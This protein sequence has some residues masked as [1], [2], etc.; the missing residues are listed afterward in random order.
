ML[1]S[2]TADDT[3]LFGWDPTPGIVS[4]WADRGGRALVWQRDG[5]RVTCTEERFRP[6]LFAATLEDLAHVGAALVEETALRAERAPFRYRE[7]DGP[8]DSYRYLL[9]AHD[10]RA[11]ERAISAGAAQRLGKPIKNLYDVEENYYWVGPVE[12]YL[13]ATGRVYFR[14]LA[15]T[16]LHRLQFDLETT[17]LSPNSG[18][19]FL[20]AVRDTQ[21]LATVL[22]AP[23]PAD[24]ASLI[25]DLCALIRARDPDIIENHNLFGFDLPFLHTRARELH[26]PLAIGRP[27]GPRLLDQYEE[28]GAFRRRKRT[29]Y[30]LAGRELIDTLDAVWRHDFSARDMPGHGLKAAARYFGVAAPQRTYI[31]GAEIF[32]TY[33]S[34]PATVRSYAQDDVMEVDGISQR[35]L[36][37]PFALAGMAPRRYE[38]LASAGPAMGILEPMLVRAYLRAGTALPRQH[39]DSAAFL[40]NHAGGATHLFAAGVAQQVVK[41]DIASMYPSIMRVFQI[42]PACDYLGAFLYLVDRLTDLRLQHKAAARTAAPYSV[43]AH[44]HNAVQAAMKILVNSAY[45]YM[46]AG[47]MALFADRPAADEVTRRGREILGHVTDALRDRGMALL[48]ADT[49]GVYFA[50][51]LGWTEEQERGVVA[52]TA[53]LLPDGIR[54]EYEGRYQAMFVHEVKNYALLT[55]GGDIIVRGGALRS[56]RSEPFGERFLR[57]ALRCTLVGNV[58]GVYQ[59]FLDVVDALRNR[60]LT[61]MD[62]ALQARLSKTPEEYEISRKRAREAAY[63]ALLT[64]GQAKWQVGERVRFFKAADGRAIWLQETRDDLSGVTEGEEIDDEDEPPAEKPAEDPVDRRDYDVEHYIQVLLTSYVG[65]LRKAF[66][67]EDFDQ[68]FRPDTQL[69]LFDRPI[70]AIQPLWIRCE[71]QEHT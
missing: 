34:D 10:G 62:V 49:D 53:A 9:S 40:G 33:Q 54:L 66:A 67:R 45:G 15:Y 69:G 61:A 57:E 14:N 30:S 60:R 46:G 41:A 65:R 32:S 19:I 27:E 68:M 43:D 18:R 5:A 25:T 51:P 70:E 17:S 36:G 28:P 13:M 11:L 38:R 22:E 56:S 71:A 48:E 20:V 7:L 4:V 23:D 47:A 26:V 44:Q 64:A 50:A 52:A 2:T 55:Y 1:P 42:G 63:E 12:Q 58:I 16:D 24:E 3:W 37:S 6:W 8:P 31:A 35:L 21:G 59:A 39:A 29:R